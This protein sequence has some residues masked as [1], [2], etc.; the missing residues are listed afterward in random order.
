M[1]FEFNDNQKELIREYR[2][3]VTYGYQKLSKIQLEKKVRVRKK[4]LYF[5]MGAMQSYS[6]SL[7]KLMGTEPVY[8]KP[9]ESLMRSQMEI[10]L[11]MRFLYSSRSEDNA[12]LFLSDLIMEPV[13]FAKKHRDLWRKYPNWNMDFGYIK[14]SEDWDKFISENLAILKKYRK[15]HGDKQFTKLPSLYDRALI[16]DKYLKKIGTFTEDRSAEKYYILYY[17]YF[18][19]ATHQSMS[20]L[21]RF[22][23][24]N[25]VSREPFLDIDSKP[26]DAERILIVSYQGYFTILHFF[27]N[28]FNTYDR[29]EYALFHK[30][31]KKIL[32]DTDASR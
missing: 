13:A 12:R 29:T 2:N 9:G 32:S 17:Q 6:E 28:V 10:W 8:E 3:L 11:N 1:A 7:L 23:R 20:G 15:K 31:S 27:L 4:V 22:L 25:G 14:K 24:G 18:S 19:Q 21:Q 16:I 26:E 5:L 30:Y